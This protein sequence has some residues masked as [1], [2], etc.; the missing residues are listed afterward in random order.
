[1]NSD[2]KNVN[3]KTLIANNSEKILLKFQTFKNCVIYLT[4]FSSTIKALIRKHVGS[5]TRMTCPKSLATCKVNPNIALNLDRTTH[6]KF[7]T[8]AVMKS[9]DRD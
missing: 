5:H 3:S 6:T 1:M 8:K 2:T 9:F 7:S 4:T